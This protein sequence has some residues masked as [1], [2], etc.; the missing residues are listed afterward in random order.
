MYYI[1]NYHTWSLKKQKIMCRSILLS[2][3]AR[4]PVQV[5]FVKRCF[6]SYTPLSDKSVKILLIMLNNP[7]RPYN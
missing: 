4:T 6:D 2:G 1:R 7:E 3:L 5:S